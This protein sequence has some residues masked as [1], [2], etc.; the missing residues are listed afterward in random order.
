VGGA[1]EV[2]TTNMKEGYLRR[3]GVP[4][5]TQTVL[6]EHLDVLQEPDG[7]TWLVVQTLVEDPVYHT[8]VILSSSNFRKQKDRSGWDPGPCAER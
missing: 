8:G 2:I 5:S 3:N 7:S 6:T 4:Y 1:L